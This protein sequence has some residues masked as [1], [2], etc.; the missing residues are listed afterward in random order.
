MWPSQYSRQ[1]ARSKSCL[2]NAI[3]AEGGLEWERR[4]QHDEHRQP[5]SDLRARF[6]EKYSE[7]PSLFGGINAHRLHGQCIDHSQIRSGV[8]DR[9]DRT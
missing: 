2:P 9:S 3:N 1:C 4:V 8:L 6:V 7:V 5:H